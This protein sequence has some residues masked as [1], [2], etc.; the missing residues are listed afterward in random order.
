M[1]ESKK[2]NKKRMLNVKKK[3]LYEMIMYK[4]V[5]IALVR[6]IIPKEEYV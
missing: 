6:H 2:S 5:I 4:V 3:L 1:I